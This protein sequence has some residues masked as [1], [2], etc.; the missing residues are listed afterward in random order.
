M[1]SRPP[2]AYPAA[3][4]EGCKA[5]D[6]IALG[7]VFRG[8]IPYLE[9]VLSRFART[10]SDLEDLL[11]AALEQAIGA[12]PRFRGDASVRTWLTRIA[13]RTALHHLKRPGE[14]PRVA[15][16][17]VAESELESAS[18]PDDEAE[19]RLRLQILKA[20][21]A[22]LDPKHHMAFVLFQIEG[23][24]ME[25]VAALTDSSISATKSRVMWARRKLVAR[26]SKDTRTR[27][28]L[29]EYGE[30]GFHDIK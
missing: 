5:G 13:V 22:Q 6:R 9:R 10:R 24:S 17:L 15:L 11:Q 3:L 16:S 19:A 8:E 12:F 14:K 7:R 29:A 4:I 23:H 2:D 27:S 18:R 20:H 28:W 26:L 1:S 21:L 30:A 25:E